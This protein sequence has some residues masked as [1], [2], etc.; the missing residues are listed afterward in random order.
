MSESSIQFVSVSVKNEEDDYSEIDKH[1]SD[2]KTR[3]NSSW[4][5]PNGKQWIRFYNL[6]VGKKKAENTE[7]S[8]V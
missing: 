5:D 8:I 1:N 4:F 3:V 7:D 2:T 6:L